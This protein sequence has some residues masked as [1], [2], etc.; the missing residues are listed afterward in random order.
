M[1]CP[2]LTSYYPILA[3]FTSK[4]TM[5]MLHKWI[6]CLALFAACIEVCH[7]CQSCV[8]DGVTPLRHLSCP[9][10]FRFVT[11]VNKSCVLDMVTP[12]RHLRCSKYLSFVTY[13]KSCVLNMVRPLRHLRCSKHLRF[14][15]YVNSCVL[16]MATP[17]R[18][19]S[20]SKYLR[21][22]TYVNSC[23]LE[24]CDSVKLGQ[25]HMQ[26]QRKLVVFEKLRLHNVFCPH[27]NA[28]WAFSNF[29]CIKLYEIIW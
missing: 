28:K 8:F 12:L 26:D 29:S 22:V 18:H 23:V 2:I 15:T 9:K 3:I 19:L 16:D 4:H 13:V 25:G 21:F 10:Y 24:I 20:C 11:Y 27:L 7:L 17:L 6:I 14:V 1:P 5:N